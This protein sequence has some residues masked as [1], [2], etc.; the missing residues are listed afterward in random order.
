MSRLTHSF[1]STKG[2]RISLIPDYEDLT[3]LT[4]EGQQHGLVK[5]MQDWQLGQVTALLCAIGDGY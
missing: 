4:G 2:G 1:K 3:G 5:G